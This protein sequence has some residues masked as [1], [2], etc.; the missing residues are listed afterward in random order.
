MKRP[1]ITRAFLYYLQLKFPKGIG[2]SYIYK[3][4]KL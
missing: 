4:N 3:N 1:S 2:I